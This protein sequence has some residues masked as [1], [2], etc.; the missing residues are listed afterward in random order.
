M[1]KA[2]RRRE[3]KARALA[4]IEERKRV[5]LRVLQECDEAGARALTKLA[6]SGRTPSCTAGCSHCCSL[7]VPMSRAE[8]EVLVDWLTA[9]RTHEELELV[10]ERLRGWLAWYRT[11]LPRLVASG[12]SRV[13]AFFRH[14]PKC[15]LLV[16]GN[17]SAYAARPV[18]CR[19]HYV[20]SPAEMCD[21]ATSTR[22]PD[23]ML[24]IPR[25]T[26]P[27]VVELRRVV[28]R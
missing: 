19:N 22:E 28:E 25:A 5:A 16:D 24:D 4:K 27:Y 8:G 6:V 17:C 10:R 7:E 23:E 18:T 13:D 15:S 1:G 20:S 21:P 14:A 9:N 2:D 12:T 26:Q 11:E 3:D